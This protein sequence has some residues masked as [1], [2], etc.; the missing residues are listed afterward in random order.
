[1]DSGPPGADA[2]APPPPSLPA[3]SSVRASAPATMRCSATDAPASWVPVSHPA[4]HSDTP[5]PPH[6]V[7]P[8]HPQL[9]SAWGRS[10]LPGSLR[11]VLT[12][13]SFQD[14]PVSVVLPAVAWVTL[15]TDTA[16]WAGW[17]RRRRPQGPL[18]R[19]R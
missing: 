6:H 8:T 18:C 10:W 2:G 16:I 3:V 17:G 15:L 14:R 11:R 1:M 4:V 9:H 13:K 7:D 19:E 12:L 5:L